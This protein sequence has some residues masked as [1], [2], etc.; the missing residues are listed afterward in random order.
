MSLHN[1]GFT[2]KP[3]TLGS[4]PSS[5]TAA[6]DTAA[7][8][9]VADD[10]E[11]AES[12]HESA[13]EKPAKRKRGNLPQSGRK[14]HADYLKYGFDFVES[15]GQLLPLCLLCQ[16]TLAN[17]SM[18]PTKLVR[19]LETTHP[20]AKHQTLDYF[21]RL[22]S[23]TNT[24]T[25]SMETFAHT[26][27][28]AIE[29]S[30]V[31]AYEIAKA[32][33]P[34]IIAEKLLKPC[35]SKAVEIMLGSSA[36]ARMDLIPLSDSTIDRRFSDMAQDVENQL[37]SRLGQSRR[38]ALQ[39]DESTDVANEAILLGF[40]RYVYEFHIV[41]DVFCFISLVDHT[42]GEKMFEA[43]DNRMQELQLDWKKVVG[44]C[45]DGA[46]SMVGKNKG[47]A[48]RISD[49][50][51]EEFS[52]SHCILHREALASKKMSPE[53]NDTLQFTVKMINHIK[54][55]ALNSRLFS[56]LCMERGS[57][58]QNVLFHAEVRWLSRGKT[59]N[60]VY[61]LR[62]ESK[63]HFGRCVDD[64]NEKGA[65]SKKPIRSDAENTQKPDK[66]VEEI[67][68]E[69]LSDPNWMSTLAY[70]ADIFDELN[71]LNLT[72]QGRKMNCFILWNRVEAFKKKLVLWRNQIK[73]NDFSAFASTNEHLKKNKPV[74]KFIQP[75]VLTHLQN[76]ITEFDNFFPTSSDPRTNFSWVV[77]PFLNVNAANTLTPSERNQLIGNLL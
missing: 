77:D 68:F 39:F 22:R 47:L 12:D 65:K 52:S 61:E 38:I 3:K 57:D 59:L 71:T 15:D 54:S 23:E 76:L 64:K 17:S 58:Y 46:Q 20:D 48:K 7:D 60:R 26:E 69:K 19:H 32:K 63:S 43:V 74:R 49:V 53:L 51:N 31:V 73:E 34:M 67:F 66:C 9:T 37:R 50:A 8:D 1:F 2:S 10:T 30:F 21:R 16:K 70:L 27:L 41:E 11:P 28:A 56:L 72:M 42:T 13:A 62:E 36:A 44:L 24:Q 29:A 5:S 4:E 35:M 18:A 75:I 25:K 14:Y 40:V 33:K 45:T 6:D 55:S